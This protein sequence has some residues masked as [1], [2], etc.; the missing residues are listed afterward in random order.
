VVRPRMLVYGALLSVGV[1]ALLVSLFTRTPLILDVIRD[2]NALYREVSG[3]R[4]ENAYTLKVINLDD[5]PHN[6][7][8]AVSGMSRLEL[9]APLAPIGAAPGT[10]STVSA[11]LQAPATIAGGVHRITLSLTAVDAPRI[12]VHE[13]ARFI[14]PQ[15]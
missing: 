2:R 13:K 10:V 3:D 11:R 6:Y 14:G 7:R 5:R 15:S 12:A 4:I 1:G 9:I 8:L